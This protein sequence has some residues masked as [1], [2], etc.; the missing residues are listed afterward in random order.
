MP[1]IKFNYRYRDGANY[2]NF[3]F[4]I[5]DNPDGVSIEVVD[6]IIKSKLIDETWFY[7]DQWHLPELYLT[8]FDSKRDPTWHEFEVLNMRMKRQILQ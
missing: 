5:F 2:K 1:N 6:S 7:A 4:V 3:G 8:T